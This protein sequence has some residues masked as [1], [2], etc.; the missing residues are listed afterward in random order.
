MKKVTAL[1]LCFAIIFSCFLSCSDRSDATQEPSESV[2]EAILESGAESSTATS[3]ETAVM[4]TQMQSAE[5]SHSPTEAMTDAPTES[6]SASSMPSES[7]QASE[8]QTESECPTEETE[9]TESATEVITGAPSFES[10]EPTE[11]PTEESSVGG[12]TLEQ[13]EE[14]TSASEQATEPI[15]TLD[16]ELLKL[17]ITGYDEYKLFLVSL[18]YDLYY[19]GGSLPNNRTIAQTIRGFF[20]EYFQDIDFADT[21]M[22]TTAVI[23]CYQQAVGDRYATYF[24]KES[25]R[26]Q[27]TDQDAE[28]VGIGVYVSYHLQENRAQILSVFKGTPAAEAGILP[29]DYLVSV[30]GVSIEEIGYYELVNRIRGEVD[31]YV[32]VGVLRDG[33]V[34]SFTM[35]RKMVE[36]VS[37][38]YRHLSQDQTIGY[39]KIEQF[40]QKTASQF[41]KA[42]DELLLNGVEGFVFDLRGNPG[43]EVGAIVDVLDYLLPDG[44]TIARFRYDEEIGF[45]KVYTSNDGH[46]VTL[47]MT[48]LCD[49]YTASAGEL[50]TAALRDHEVATVIG[51]TTYGKGTAQSLIELNDG[52]AFTISVARYDPPSGENYEGV[53]IVPHIAVALNEEAAKINAFLRDDLIDNQLQ[54][55]VAELDRLR[56]ASL[57]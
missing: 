12:E 23:A 37:V 32:T 28:F 7:L 36:G 17:G 9:E 29:G 38:S 1:C 25:Y 19:I 42:I 30:D 50:F 15:G 14:S 56:G 48:V 44:K 45:D 40:D 2:T 41:K 3:A 4:G 26:E 27:Q 51:E 16:E 34:L 55:A 54:T 10:E 22:M 33:E 39:V 31:T 6:A 11:A 46:E 21:E 5:E 53:G 24:D 18:Y 52:T 43:G 35:Q 57:Q 20:D 8:R 13:T 49:S 47:P